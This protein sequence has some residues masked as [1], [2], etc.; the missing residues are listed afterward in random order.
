MT[1]LSQKSIRFISS[2]FKVTISS[3][4]ELEV[5]SYGLTCFVQSMSVFIVLTVLGVLFND[6]L[7][8]IIWFSSFMLLRNY[9]GGLHASNPYSCFLFSILIAMSS[10]FCEQYLILRD[11][12]ILFYHVHVFILIYIILTAPLPNRKKIF[13]SEF[14][15]KNKIK[16]II[17]C[18]I[19]ENLIQ[20][21]P[22]KQS[23]FLE[24][25]LYTVIVLSLFEVIK[26]I[27]ICQ[28][29]ML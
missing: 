12:P 18:I 6:L 16:A 8:I 28:K 23:Y 21:L 14:V 10:F 19:I 17:V 27:F 13:S 25:A 1:P 22:E 5:Y 4:D 9:C 2:F 24:H 15:F 11:S 29:N 26:R 7:G 3:A 20:L